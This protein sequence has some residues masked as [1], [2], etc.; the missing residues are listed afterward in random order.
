MLSGPR[1]L[2]LRPAV[3]A[4]VDALEAIR[5][6]PGVTAWWG[7]PEP[8]EIAEAIAGDDD[9]VLLAFEVAG[10][11]AGAIQYGE[12]PDPMYRHASIDVYLG[13]AHQGRGHG[14]VAVDLLARWLL[15]PEPLGRGHHRLVIDPAAANVRAISAYAHVGF[16]PVGRLRQYER[17]PDGT[18]HDGLLMELLRDDL[19]AD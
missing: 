15:A 14:R 3:P 10:A 12:E 2:L 5:S 8:G 6:E 18:F 19:D 9:V 17:G 13:E 4:D 16:R 7:E 1:G 11:V